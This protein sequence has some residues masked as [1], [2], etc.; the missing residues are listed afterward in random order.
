MIGDKA[1]DIDPSHGIHGEGA[2]PGLQAPGIYL[3]IAHAPVTRTDNRVQVVLDGLLHRHACF[4]TLDGDPARSFG[5]G[6]LNG[7]GW[8]RA[9]AVDAARPLPLDANQPSVGK[10]ARRGRLG[11]DA[12]VETAAVGEQ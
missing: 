1:R 5:A 2:E 8:I 7:D 10:P 4:P 12:K 9:D 6:V 3:H 11:P